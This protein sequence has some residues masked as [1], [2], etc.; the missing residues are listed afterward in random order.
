LKLS[1]FILSA[2]IMFLLFASTGTRASPA[3]AQAYTSTYTPTE[4]NLYC[5]PAVTGT[6]SGA[7][8]ICTDPGAHPINGYYVGHDEPSLQFFSSTAGS[9][10][11]MQWTMVLPGLDSVPTQ[12]GSAI[13]TFENYIAFW[14]SLDL[15][16]PTSYPQGACTPLSDTNVAATTGSALLELQFYP[17]GFSTGGLVLTPVSCDSTHWC[18]ALNIDSLECTSGFAACN[19]GCTEP[20]NFALIQT[21]GVPAGPPGPKTATLAS[22][23]PNAK[24]LLMSPSDKIKVTIKDNG[25]ALET[26]V[27]DITAGT[28]GFMVASAANHFQNANAG[29][30]GLGACGTSNFSDFNF[31]PEFSTASATNLGPWEQLSV[32]VN[33][34]VETGHFELCPT[35]PCTAGADSDTDDTGSCFL[36]G[37]IGGCFGKDADFDGIPYGANWPD[38]AANHPTSVMLSPPLS[39]SSGTYSAGYGT[40]IFE[41]DII[42]SESSCST[43]TGVGCTV[44]PTNGA[45]APVFY[46]FYSTTSSTT[47]DPFLFGNDQ[48]ATANDYGKDAQYGSATARVYAPPLGPM[49]EIFSSTPTSTPVCTQGDHIGVPEFSMPLLMTSTLAFFA[50]ALVLR[51]KRDGLASREISG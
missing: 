37:P 38:G 15:C 33:F 45:G 20:V 1:G 26:D 4:N 50:L 19:P 51:F 36:P 43:A 41:T 44:P 28:S 16:D 10:N 23:T 46:P 27:N 2:T 22:F 49:F 7:N 8:L 47:C 25:V 17:P 11:N 40:F 14:F 21:D 32:N 13:A 12:S 24:T 9:A 39:S 35:G 3:H 6:L 48:P 18:A 5:D 31:R 29:T 42:T 34:A 30:A